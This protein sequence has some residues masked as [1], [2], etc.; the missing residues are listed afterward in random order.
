MNRSAPI[1]TTPS[2][3]VD[4][5]IG[6]GSNIRPESGL[7]AGI[8]ALRAAFGELEVSSVYRSPAFGFDG[9]DFLNVV[10][11]V[12][13]RLDPDAV[14]ARLD[15]IENSGALPPKMGRFAPRAL[16]C[17]LL[18]YGGRVDARRRLPRDDV[19]RYPF[20]LGPLAQIAPQLRHP[21]DGR[22]IADHWAQRRA[23]ARLQRICTIDELPP[24]PADA[25]SP[26]D[27][28]DLSGY[29]GRVTSEI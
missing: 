15:A 25:A 18:M 12:R 24:L 11:T 16:D 26:V 19:L 13:T 3:A 20:V 6:V 9:D 29:I 27:G 22:A 23:D 28:E 2:A 14:E 1:P 7:R 10:L 5:Y 8:E 17:D 4:V 21:L